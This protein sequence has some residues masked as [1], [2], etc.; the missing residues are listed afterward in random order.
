[1]PGERAGKEEEKNGSMAY[2]LMSTLLP[3]ALKPFEM[4]SLIK[5]V[6]SIPLLKRMPHA[7]TVLKLLEKRLF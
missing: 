3:D 2:S 4:R 6:S 7:K 5:G 1:M